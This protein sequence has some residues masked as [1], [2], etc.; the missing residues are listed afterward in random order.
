MEYRAIY[1]CRLCGNKYS[2]TA[3]GNKDIAYRTVVELTV[4]GYSTEPQAP[5]MTAPH[6]CPSGSI[7][8]ADFQG[9]EKVD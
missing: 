7:G 8:V 9:W 4:L 1:K 2:C 5:T 3:T 6:P